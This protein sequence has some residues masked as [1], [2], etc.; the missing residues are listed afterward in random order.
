MK[1]LETAK[2]ALLLGAAIDLEAL[3]LAIQTEIDI[4]E[5][6][7]EIL[8]NYNSKTQD[9]PVEETEKKTPVEETEKEEES[10]DLTE[11]GNVTFLM[12][13]KSV[14]PFKYDEMYNM[15][16]MNDRLYVVCE[17]KAYRIYLSNDP[18]CMYRFETKDGARFI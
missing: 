17:Q 1:E 13:T 10:E 9:T 18:E 4:L 11:Y 16:V 7:I 3:S 8:E 14:G 6:Y 5:N 12:C 15:V 2:L